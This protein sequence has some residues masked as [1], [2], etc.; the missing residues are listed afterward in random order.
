[1]KMVR[2]IF[3]ENI[4]H[5]HIPGIDEEV[6]MIRTFGNMYST[7]NVQFRLAHLVGEYYRS[8]EHRQRQSDR[9][10]ARPQSAAQEKEG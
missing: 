5:N 9:K 1:M 7:H 4:F 6:T 2:F 8:G 10:T 3:V